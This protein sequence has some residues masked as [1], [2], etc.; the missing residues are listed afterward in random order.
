MAPNNHY[1]S[2]KISYR[3]R[4]LA[5]LAI[6]TVLA[7]VLAIL[8]MDLTVFPIALF[9]VSHTGL[10]ISVI[11]YMLWILFVLI[12]LYPF[13]RRIIHLKKNGVSTGTVIRYMVRR[14][15]YFISVFFVFAVISF[16]IIG[17]LYVL[18]HNNHLLLHRLLAAV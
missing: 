7:A 4:E 3:S 18:M 11:K 16:V 14:S 6:F 17:L 10:F 12:L 5:T 8:V 2:G 13:I 1:E 15:G 9:A